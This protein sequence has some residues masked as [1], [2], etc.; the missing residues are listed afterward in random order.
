MIN[1]IDGYYAKAEIGAELDD[2]AF[3][4]S[5]NDMINAAG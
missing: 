3:I 1:D 5:L 4:A 2:T